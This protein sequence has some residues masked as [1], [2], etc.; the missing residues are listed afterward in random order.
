MAIFFSH[1]MRTLACFLQN[2]IKFLVSFGAPAFGVSPGCE[3]LPKENTDMY[4]V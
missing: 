3:N 4:V 2:K 1:T